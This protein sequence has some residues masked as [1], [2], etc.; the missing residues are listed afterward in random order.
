MYVGGDAA[1]APRL[2]LVHVSSGDAAEVAAG[3]TATLP[4]SAAG[5]W[6]VEFHHAAPLAGDPEADWALY[7]ATLVFEA[8]GAQEA[9]R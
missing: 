3:G 4:L 7:T 9:G 1:A 6:R 2:R 8:P 5:R